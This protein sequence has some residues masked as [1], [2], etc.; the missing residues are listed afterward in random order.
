MQVGRF[1]V[2]A[3]IIANS[4]A[5]E[6]ASRR[7]FLLDFAANQQQIR[8][9]QSLLRSQYVAALRR[10]FNDGQFAAC[11]QNEILLKLRRRT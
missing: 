1:I 4:L 3:T 2:S 8:A 9:Y 5:P 7:N 10:Q 6:R 11:F